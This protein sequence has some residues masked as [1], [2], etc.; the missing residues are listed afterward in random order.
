MT[1]DKSSSRPRPPLN[2]DYIAID[3]TYRCNLACSFCFMT[4]SASRIP[5]GR[6]LSLAAWKKFIDSLSRKPREFYI[7]GGEPCLRKDLPELVAHIKKGGHRCLITTNGCSLDIKTAGRLL[8]AGLDE[9]T[10]SLHGTRELHDA[11]VGHKGAFAKTAAVCAFINSSPIKGVKHLSFWCAINAA[12]HDKL[13]S[14]YKALK[15]LGPD[16]IAFNQLDFIREKDRKKTAGLF[17]KELGCGLNLKA[18]ESMAEG[19]S[20]PKL[21]AE[22]RKIKS[23]KD[24]D[25]RFDL[26]LT[27][28]ELELWYGPKA[29]FTKKGFCLG[30]WNGIWVG[31]NGD[32]VSCQPLG[33]VVGNITDGDWLETYNGPAYTKFRAL[34]VKQGGFLPT[35]SRCG[36][37]S[38]TSAHV[39]TPGAAGTLKKI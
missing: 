39:D 1:A 25:I 29:G 15:T 30:Q 4:K 5:P 34:L 9:I 28:D 11:I 20:V 38:Y 33:H 12:N 26:D 17:S 6:E 21:A 23:E 14:V 18:S 22:I 24:P 31:A 36:R 19:I 3:T 10:V 16:H 35:C 13:Y 32:I 8:K 7:A 2:P 27:E 37:T